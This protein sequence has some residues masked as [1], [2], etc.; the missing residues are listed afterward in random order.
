[1]I[2]PITFTPTVA[3][4]VE[5]VFHP[6]YEDAVANVPIENRQRAIGKLCEWSVHNE[7]GKFS[8]VTIYGGIQGDITATYRNKEGE[9]TYSIMA[10]LN[11]DGTYSFHS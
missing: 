11:D 7:T 8:R 10:V 1:M 6:D 5:F 4:S 3:R 2:T 9:P